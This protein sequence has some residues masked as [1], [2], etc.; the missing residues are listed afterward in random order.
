MKGFVRFTELTERFTTRTDDS[1][2]SRISKVYLR[3]H[4]N[5]L[6]QTMKF[7]IGKVFPVDGIKRHDPRI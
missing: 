7:Q 4:L 2:V 1:Y 6:T 5:G 3:T